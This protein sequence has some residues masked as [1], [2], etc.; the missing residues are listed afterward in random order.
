MSLTSVV[1]DNRST[2]SRQTTWF[3]AV[4][5][6]AGVAYLRA[7]QR[8]KRTSCTVTVE[9]PKR[10]FKLAVA[11]EVAGFEA[12][13]QILSELDRKDGFV[14]LSDRTSPPKVASLFFAGAKD[15]HI[16]EV[17]ATKLAH[18]VHWIVGVMG[19]EPPGTDTLAA[20]ETTVHYLMSDGC[21]HVYGQAGVSMSSVVR[22]A[23]VP[24]G[25][26]GKHVFPAWL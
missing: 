9:V 4:G 17:D 26:D 3:V 2:W 24:L 15:L 1:I 13:G 19:D 10:V 22:K 23:H 25:T 18:P 8:K 21:V 20:S 16:L 6:C 5:V 11:A 12:G 7:R 14:H